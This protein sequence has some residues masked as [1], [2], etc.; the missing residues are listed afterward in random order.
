MAMNE[1]NIDGGER[2]ICC[3]CVDN[4]QGRGKSETLKK[5]GDSTVYGTGESE[6]DKEEAEEKVI[7]G[8]GDEFSVM[9]FVYP[10]WTV[11]VSS[12]GSFLSVV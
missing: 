12:L 5:V 10:C 3:D 6:E 11:I 9:P 8:G 7:G 1:I 2:K 4:I